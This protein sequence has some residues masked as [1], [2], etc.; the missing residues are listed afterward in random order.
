MDETASSDRTADIRLRRMTSDEKIDLT[1]GSG[2]WHTTPLPRHGVRS[3][4]MSDGPNGVRNEAGAED[5]GAFLVAVDGGRDTAR[6]PLRRSRPQT[7][8]PS[9]SAL[10]NSWDPAL[11]TEVGSALAAECRDA[12]IDMLLGPGINIRRSPLAGRGFEYFSEDPVLTGD[13]AAGF[14][15]GLQEGGVGAVL[16]HFACNNSET[17]RTSMNSVVEPRALHEIYLLAFER[18]IARGNPDAVMA[19]YNRLNGT[20]CS[21]HRW[22]LAE[23][24]RKRWNYHGLVMSDWYGTVDLPAALSAGLDL[25]MPESP[26][27]KRRLRDALEQNSL[28]LD[29]LDRACA[30]IL[31]LVARCDE[32][33][34][35]TSVPVDFDVHHRLAREA[36]ARSCVLL[37][38]R[39]DLLPLDRGNGRFLLVGTLAQH[40]VIQGAGSAAM[41]P[42]RCDIPLDVFAAFLEPGASVDFSAGWLENGDWDALRA[43]AALE[44]AATAD[45]VIVFAGTASSRSG[46]N[47]DR[48]DIELLPAHD[49]LIRQLAERHDRVVI[50]VFNPD[51]VAMPWQ[52]DVGAILLAGYGGQGIG[53][54]VVSL[55]LGEQSPSGKLSVTFP[56][57]LQDAPSFLGYPGENGQHLYREGIFVGYR[58]YDHCGIEPAF[59]FG[60]GLSYTSFGYTD[61]KITSDP[62][63]TGEAVHVRFTLT[64]TGARSG[65]EICQL[66]LGREPASGRTGPAHPVRA[67]KAFA[68]IELEPGECTQVSFVLASRDFAYFDVV[69]DEWHIPAGPV[70]IQIG[71]S[72][73]DIRLHGQVF[74]KADRAIHCEF[75]LHTPP[76][77]ILA[78][79]AGERLIGAWLAGTTGRNATL[80]DEILEKSRTSFLGIYDTLTW[81]LGSEPGEIS[82]Q[83]V[84]DDINRINRDGIRRRGTGP[85]PDTVKS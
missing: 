44:A 55:L 70:R 36:A 41:T 31:R 1:S 59:P 47:A 80:I 63:G 15:R 54:A 4:R 7:C 5:P 75:D 85:M 11:A 52:G 84:L 23:T 50:V 51:A 20:H 43:E 68:A 53:Y 74:T 24:L 42:S 21:Q 33:A 60:F 2:L 35:T 76:G 58:H 67:L 57:R 62:A 12:G 30:S 28:S 40:P 38:N 6:S 48:A 45:T 82:L 73:R 46:E 22:L 13:L 81:S 71:A 64:N 79:S 83:A 56:G 49:A 8:F 18:A 10:G 9:G 3:L 65:R 77:A 16:K 61:L 26:V 25:A 37:R 78:S 32:R 69:L 19:S 29:Q 14:I 17:E 34:S 72:S 66:Y 39:N 27:R